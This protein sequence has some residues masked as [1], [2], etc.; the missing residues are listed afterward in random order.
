M[1]HWMVFKYN[2]ETIYFS[3]HLLS[4]F[5]SSTCNEIALHN[6]SWKLMQNLIFFSHLNALFWCRKV[7]YK[8]QIHVLSHYE[9][10]W[11]SKKFWK[12]AIFTATFKIEILINIQKNF[13]CFLWKLILI[14]FQSLKWSKFCPMCN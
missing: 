8:R 13:W 2:R 1:F 11:F 10:V 9:K 12:R 5:V 7:D 4:L 6:S 3:L 14:T